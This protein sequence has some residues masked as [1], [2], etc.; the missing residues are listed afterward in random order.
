MNAI[1]ITPTTDASRF[2]NGEHDELTPAEFEMRMRTGFHSTVTMLCL[3]C[4]RDLRNAAHD[5]LPTGYMY[6]LQQRQAA[7]EEL[8]FEEAVETERTAQELAARWRVK[9]YGSDVRRTS[10][11][12]SGLAVAYEVWRT[13]GRQGAPMPEPPPRF[14]VKPMGEG[15]YY[16]MQFNP[17][18]YY[19]VISE[20][21]TRAKANEMLAKR[22]R[23]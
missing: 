23:S 7:S 18:G 22:S 13:R 5:A 12:A 8:I 14:K 3:R 10:D 17:A 16:L 1:T 2:C 4:L 20:H 6:D 15:R 21:R 9:G 11:A 19:D